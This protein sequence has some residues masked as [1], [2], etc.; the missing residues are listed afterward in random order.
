MLFLTSLVSQRSVTGG[1]R[2]S[3]ILINIQP[4]G[5]ASGDQVTSLE[6]IVSRVIKPT[7]SE[8]HPVRV[9][10]DE[11]TGDFIKCYTYKR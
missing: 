8:F 9:N 2:P 10:T 11:A 3:I 7:R 5:Q 1:L 6:T 4:F